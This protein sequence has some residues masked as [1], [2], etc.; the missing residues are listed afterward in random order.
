MRMGGTLVKAQTILKNESQNF[1]GLAKTGG[2]CH[3]CFKKELSHHGK[4]FSLAK[5]HPN[6]ILKLS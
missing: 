5:W 6:K 3:V 4:E 1:F 2:N